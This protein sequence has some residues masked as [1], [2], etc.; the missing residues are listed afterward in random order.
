MA[1][2]GLGRELVPGETAFGEGVRGVEKGWAVLVEAAAGAP[3][4][5]GEELTEAAVA[6]ERVK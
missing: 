1:C 4:V 3:V 5:R 2:L 6:R